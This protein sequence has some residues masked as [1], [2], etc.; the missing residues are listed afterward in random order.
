[1]LQ[2]YFGSMAGRLFLLLLVG[3]PLVYGVWLSLEDRPVARAGTFIGLANFLGE[4]N[5]AMLAANFTKDQMTYSGIL[6]S[7]GLAGNNSGFN[8]IFLRWLAK[9]IKDRGLQN[10]YQKW[11][12]KNAE[13][14][15][16]VRR[17]SDDLAWCQ[18]HKPT[19]AGKNLHSWDCIASLEALQVVPLTSIVS[20]APVRL[21]TNVMQ[22]PSIK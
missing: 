3:Y 9:F 4:T 20:P 8:A 10:T 2:R 13:T 1:M 15:W 14:A 18:W 19:P 7:Y 17:T 12:Q 21:N 11:L 5:D 16:N 6:P 22:T